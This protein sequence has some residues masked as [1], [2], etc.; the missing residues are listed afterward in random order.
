VTH[1]TPKP[2]TKPSGVLAFTGFGQTGQLM[3]LLG[4]LLVIIGL[5]LYFVDV[6][7]AASWLLGM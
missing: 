5:V 6:R 1:V 7:K 3:A 2:V 4:L